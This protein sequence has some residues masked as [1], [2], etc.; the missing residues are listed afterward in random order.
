MAGSNMLF[1]EEWATVATIDPDQYSGN[2][3]EILSDEIDMSGYEQLVAICLTGDANTAGRTITC[4]FQATATSGG[5]YAAISG[6]SAVFGDESPLA[7]DAQIFLELRGDEVTSNKRYV[8]LSATFAS[9]SSPL[10]SPDFAAIVLGRAK[11][12]PATDADLS[13]VREIV[14]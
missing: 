8:K 14:Q 9:T 10:G 6:K 12:K 13:S 1:T 11:H 4:A 2:G 5:A 3:G 7:K